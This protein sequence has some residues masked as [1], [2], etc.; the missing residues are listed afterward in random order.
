MREERLAYKVVLGTQTSESNWMTML[1]RLLYFTAAFESIT[2]FTKFDGM[3][4]SPVIIAI[5]ILYTVKR[6]DTST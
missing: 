1:Q 4:I 6:I 2:F 5:E 3:H